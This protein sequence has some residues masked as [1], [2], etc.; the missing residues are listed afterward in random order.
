[1]ECYIESLIDTL[2]EDSYPKEIDLVLDG[3]TF[4]GAYTLGCLRYLKVLEK[5]NIVKVVRISGCSIGAFLAVAYVGNILESMA[6][7]GEKMIQDFRRDQCLQRLHERSEDWVR[8]HVTDNTIK[9][10]EKRVT[11][12]YHDAELKKQVAVDSF[13]TKEQLTEVLVRSAFLPFVING[14][15]H[16]QYKYFDGLTPALFWDK[17]RP[18]IFIST[19]VLGYIKSSIVMKGTDSIPMRRLEGIEDIHH[20]FS[21]AR[22]SRLCSYVDK[23]SI[24]RILAFRLR[25]VAAMLFCLT[26]DTAAAII[27]YIPE[28]IKNHFVVDWT[29]QLIRDLIRDVVAWTCY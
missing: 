27:Q 9:E 23:W 20:F 10:M 11:I 1:M 13:D 19:M 4:N 24:V 18:S 8:N 14:M 7:I 3:G 16:Y 15:P 21:R 26:S 22:A 6:D 2:P 25:S 28:W 29:K 12:T 17:T 5:R